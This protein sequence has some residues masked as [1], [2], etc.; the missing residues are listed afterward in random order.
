ML[1]D[2]EGKALTRRVEA[3]SRRVRVS[4]MVAV[5]ALVVAL[6]GGTAWAASRYLITST[7]QIK[8]SGSRRS[9]A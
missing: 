2:E 1:T 5:G 7:K 6:A 8:P 3:L 4:N 9:S